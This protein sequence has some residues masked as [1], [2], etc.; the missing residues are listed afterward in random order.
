MRVSYF[1]ATLVCCAAVV[2]LIQ[3]REFTEECVERA[4]HSSCSVFNSCCD[5]RCGRARLKRSTCTLNATGINTRQTECFCT[6]PF[7][8]EAHPQKRNKLSRLDLIAGILFLFV[9]DM[10]ILSFTF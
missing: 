3:S 4:H 9:V 1:T 8:P 10:L 2:P 7:T 5:F 6:N